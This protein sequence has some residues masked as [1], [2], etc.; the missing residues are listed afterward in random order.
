MNLQNLVG[1]HLNMARHAAMRNVYRELD[2]L[3]RP[4]DTTALMLARDQPGCDQAML[5][6]ALSGNR[7][8]GMKV[9]SRLEAKGLMIRASGRDGRT[10][11]L[12]ITPEGDRM[13]TEALRRHEQAE[14]KLL[15]Y[16]APGERDISLRLLVNVQ[17]AIQDAEA[18]VADQE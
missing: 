6:R 17:Q 3:L 18:A 13:L 12:Y 16:L 7:S 4:A 10:K 8:V 2:G 5:G 15:A 9:A 1:Y 11:G 14:A